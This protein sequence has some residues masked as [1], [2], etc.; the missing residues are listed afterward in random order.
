[1]RVALM[2]A[3]RDKLSYANVV[4]TL[5][6]VLL[7]GGGAAYAASH[8]GKNSVGPKQLKKNAVTT[9]KIKNEAVTAAK[10]KKGTLTG[11]QINASTV[12]TVP[13]ATHAQTANSA[14]TAGI[15]NGVAAPEPFH[16]VGALGE[17]QFQNGCSN[18]AAGN[19]TVAF[20]KD[21][22]GFVHLK[23]DYI[24]GAAGKVAFQLPAGYR[25]A[26]GTYELFPNSGSSAGS[27]NVWIAG[28][29]YEKDGQV[30]GG[31]LCL[32]TICYLDGIT[33][34]AES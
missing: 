19:A 11:T 23:G 17:P 20:L 14:D 33:F 32:E 6:L 18:N 29:G 22:E 24:C 1:M 9:A 4:S 30:E 8:L 5:C 34:R 13:T 2:N 26:S 16:E 31:V 3:L 27:V 28:T 10:V 7:L 21:R 12:G 25:P 15:A